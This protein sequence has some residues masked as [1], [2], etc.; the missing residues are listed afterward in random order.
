[1]ATRERAPRTGTGPRGG[2][3]LVGG[4]GVSQSVRGRYRLPPL[5]LLDESGSG[6]RG[7]FAV[8]STG[9]GVR[10]VGAPSGP[11][12]PPPRPPQPSSTD[13]EPRAGVD[14]GLRNDLTRRFCHRLFTRMLAH[15]LAKLA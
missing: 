12:R 4:G 15:L 11:R 5:A 8:T 7:R 2:V 1:M 10:V 13:Q 14:V 3:G 6:Q 9:S